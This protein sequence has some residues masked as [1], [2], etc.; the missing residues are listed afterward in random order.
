MSRPT[1]NYDVVTAIGR[2]RLMLQETAA[3]RTCA[4]FRSHVD[5]KLLNH[6]SV[7][8][9]VTLDNQDASVKHPIEVVQW[10]FT[11]DKRSS[12]PPIAIETTADTGLTHKRWTISTARFGAN[13][14]YGSFFICLRDEPELDYG[15][16]RHSDGQGFAVFGEIIDGH[17]VVESLF[18]LA[19][20]SEVLTPTVEILDV[21]ATDITPY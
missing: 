16:R 6:T 18:A 9:I 8:R 12:A 2:F 15:G 11:P 13:E 1:S 3:P 20:P 5:S 21:R 17:K 4:Y 10:G 14:P 7:F 19:G